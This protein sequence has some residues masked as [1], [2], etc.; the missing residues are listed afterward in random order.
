MAI[1]FIGEFDRI[2]RDVHYGPVE[3]LA[4]LPTAQQQVTFTAGETKSSALNAQTRL[5][6]LC[7]DTTCYLS[8]GGTATSGGGIRL[9]AGVVEIW[10]IYDWQAKNGMQISVIA[11]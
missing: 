10:A 2:G 11:E 4:A 7:S 9:P 3:A 5:V 6:R 1:L 8:F